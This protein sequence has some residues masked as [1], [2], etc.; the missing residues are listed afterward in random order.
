MLQTETGQ[1]FT[2]NLRTKLE[3]QPGSCMATFIQFPSM[4]VH[5]HVCRDWQTT[6]SH[7]ATTIT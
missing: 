7:Y 6:L 4:S 2:D 3:L 5:T 1:K